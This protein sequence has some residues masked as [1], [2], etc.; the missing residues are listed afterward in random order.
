MVE[1]RDSERFQKRE[2]S[3]RGQLRK[4]ASRLSRLIEVLTKWQSPSAQPDSFTIAFCDHP[5][6]GRPGTCGDALEPGRFATPPEVHI[7]AVTSTPGRNTGDQ[8]PEDNAGNGRTTQGTEPFGDLRRRQREPRKLAN[9]H[10]E[11]SQSHVVTIRRADS[12]IQTPSGGGITTSWGH[13]GT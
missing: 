13:V 7:G 6:A 1:E 4:R 2:Q 8:Q 3:P 10:N 12:P 9:R 11:N 5:P